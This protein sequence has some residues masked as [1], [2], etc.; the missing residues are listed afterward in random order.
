MFAVVGL[1]KKQYKVAA[2]D[3]IKVESLPGEVG[4][5][6][7]LPQVYLL[8]D[9]D[10]LKVGTPL[11]K[12]AKVTAKI[13]AQEKA[14]K[15]L[16]FKKKRRKK[17]RRLFGHRQNLTALKIQEISVQKAEISVQKAAKSEK[18]EGK[19]KVAKAE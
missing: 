3:I 16:V 17:Y 10:S 2:G 12:G 7:E 8:K 14:P 4:Q 19:K 13:V 1:G 6:I 11:L 9:N 5:E 18:P 15:I